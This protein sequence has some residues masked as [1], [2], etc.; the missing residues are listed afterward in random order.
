[1]MAA[2]AAPATLNAPAEAG[3]SR[4]DAVAAQPLAF[5]RKKQNAA[6]VNEM[7]EKPAGALAE[8][9]AQWLK[10][11]LELRKEGKTKEAEEELTRFRKR[12]PDYR[13]PA[14]LKSDR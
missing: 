4:A 10:R 13:L 14:E 12:Y 5:A 9:P 11:I 3:R 8:S 1:M 2:P 7:E 6:N